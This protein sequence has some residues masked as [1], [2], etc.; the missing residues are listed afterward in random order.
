MLLNHE[1]DKPVQDNTIQLFENILLKDTNYP[2]ALWVIA[3]HEILINNF[4]RAE[5]LLNR[6]LIQLSEGSEEY[7]L[8]INKLKVFD[9]K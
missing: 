6:L 7:N 8:V 2:L 9:N 1:K 3:E 5:K 4:V